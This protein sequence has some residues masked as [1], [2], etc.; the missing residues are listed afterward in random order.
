MPDKTQ[1]V[2]ESA[3]TRPGPSDSPIIITTDRSASRGI[4]INAGKEK[5]ASAGNNTFK[6]TKKNAPKEIL[7]DDKYPI[8][9]ASKNAVW[10]LDLSDASQIHITISG[11]E[12][13]SDVQIQ[14]VDN[15]P[16]QISADSATLNHPGP[17]D[18]THG[19]HGAAF[20]DAGPGCT[21]VFE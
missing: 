21:I 10:T 9:I 15:A 4:H 7:F 11:F 2:S 3:T 14:I 16:V 19:R 13:S 6:V 8:P 1:T 5:F 18:R 20:H 12:S 17:Y